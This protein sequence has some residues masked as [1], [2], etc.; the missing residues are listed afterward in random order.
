MKLEFV[1]SLHLAHPFIKGFERTFYCKTPEELDSVAR[2]EVPE[3]VQRRSIADEKDG[4]PVHTT[5]FYIGLAI[6]PKLR[7]SH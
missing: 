1:D 5:T 7:A 2:G 3:P 4:D 6:E